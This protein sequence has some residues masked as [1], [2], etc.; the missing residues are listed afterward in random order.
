MAVWLLRRL[1]MVEWLVSSNTQIRLLEQQ[2]REA[3][4]VGDAERAQEL[5]GEIL[6]HIPTRPL[7]QR[8]WYADDLRRA[9]V[10]YAFSLLTLVYYFAAGGG[11]LA[12]LQGNH[13]PLRLLFA[14]VNLL[15]LA[16]TS[17]PNLLAREYAQGTSVFLRLTRLNGWDL[18]YGAYTAYTLGGALRLYLLWGVP[19]LVP[20]AT[21]IYGSLGTA[22]LFV[23]RVGLCIAAVG[24]LWQTFLGL[25]TRPRAALWHQV[26]MY[27]ILILIMLVA[28]F[29]APSAA[30][31]LESFGEAQW[32]N[33]AS[34]WEWTLRSTF[35]ASLLFLPLGMV[36]CVSITHPAWGTLH[37]LV[38]FGATALL[39]P[40][41]ARRLQR[42]LNAPEPEPKAPQEGAWW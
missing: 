38:A 13:A 15:P 10:M 20:L 9:V 1:M 35:W 18:L 40:L 16:Y 36:L 33:Q 37:A 30:Q 7:H 26:M 19:V 39:A 2:R 41:A 24:V 27:V 34:V 25:F 5:A 8:F 28:M 29:S 42:L 12:P 6:R 3:L 17:L 22:L 4:R 21:A 32:F 31:A 23:V 14:F 11:V